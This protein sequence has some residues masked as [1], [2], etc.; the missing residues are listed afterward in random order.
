MTP[1]SSPD[2]SCPT[3]SPD[4]LFCLTTLPN[5]SQ[6][7][8]DAACSSHGMEVWSPHTGQ[9]QLSDKTILAWVQQIQHSNN[10]TG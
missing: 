1:S 6:P 5:I 4:G 7:D 8:S 9:Y 3:G 2:P 10:T